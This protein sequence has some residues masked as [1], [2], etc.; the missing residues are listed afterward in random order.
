MLNTRHE[1]GIS[2]L[3]NAKAFSLTAHADKVGSVP[4]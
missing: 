1:P 3:P 4:L 2:Q